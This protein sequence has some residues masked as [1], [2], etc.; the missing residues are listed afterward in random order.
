M[1]GFLF[2][3]ALASIVLV[4]YAA[5]VFFLW[6]MDREERHIEYKC[7]DG[8]LYYRSNS[9]GTHP[10]FK[11]LGWQQFINAQGQSEVCK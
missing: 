10:E 7:I 2:P 11:N 4:V 8:H 5:F 1:K 9:N 6:Q 3:C